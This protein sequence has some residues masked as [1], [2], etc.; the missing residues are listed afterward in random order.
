MSEIWK[1][2]PGYEGYY[3]VSDQGRV[4]SVERV[5][6]YR[7]GRVFHYR[8]RVLRPGY[9]KNYGYYQVHLNRYNVGKMVSIHRLVALVFI[10]NPKGYNVVNHKDENPLN[11]KAENLE[12]CSFQYNV[13]YGTK[14]ERGYKNG[15]G[16]RHKRI[17]K[18]DLNGN[19]VGEWESIL[20]AS[21][22]EGLSNTTIRRFARSEKSQRNGYVYKFLN[23]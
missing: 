16:S 5:V 11:N 17:V 6:E 13:A 15:A 1:A 7:D 18:Y 23:E 4:R 21:V 14:F 10:P 22:A 19:K 2:I 20:K 12:W 3:E 8:S 9:S